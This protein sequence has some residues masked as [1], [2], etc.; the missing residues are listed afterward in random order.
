MRKIRFVS[1]NNKLFPYLNITFDCLFIPTKWKYI[2]TGGV[3]LKRI[4]RS[5]LTRII[6]FIQT[7]FLSL[8]SAQEEYSNQIQNRVHCFLGGSG[9]LRKVVLRM[10]WPTCHEHGT[11]KAIDPMTFSTLVGCSSHLQWATKDSWLA[12]PYTRFMY[13]MRSA[14]R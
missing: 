1:Y 9:G 7:R 4:K 6:I 11:K 14:Y 2:V 13:D 8:R 3:P 5:Q 12:R 10:I